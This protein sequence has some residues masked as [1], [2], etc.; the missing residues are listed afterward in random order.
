MSGG[1][2]MS[3]RIQTSRAFRNDCAG[4]IPDSRRNVIRLGP[5]DTDISG[6]G[7]G[8]WPARARCGKAPLPLTRKAL[9]SLISG[10]VMWFRRRRSL[11]A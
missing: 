2:A 4:F 6:C 3:R 5:D 11:P 7:I 8:V 10:S 9:K 1:V